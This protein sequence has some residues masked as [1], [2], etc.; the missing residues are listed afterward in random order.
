M[1]RTFK[2][3]LPIILCLVIICSI[4]WY[5]FSYDRGFLQDMLLGSARYFEEQGNH[6]MATWLYKQAYLH[7]GN[8]DDVVIE[9]AERFIKI[10]NYTQAEVVLA[11]AIKEGASVELYIALSKT[12]VEQDKLLDAV[13]MLENITNPDIK[14]Q[15]DAMRPAAPVA[16]PASGYY[17]QYMNITINYDESDSLYVA[18]DKD[19]P[20]VRDEFSGGITLVGGENY[21]NAIVVNDLGLVS[22]PAYFSYIVGGVIEEVSIS[23]P[24]L[25]SHLR[26]ILNLSATQKMFTNDL[27]TI[28]SLTVPQGVTDLSDLSKLTYLESLTME[29]VPIETLQ[30]LSSMTQLNSLTIRGCPLS[31]TD[32]RFIA[33][34]PSL[35][36]LTLNNCALTNISSLENASRLVYLDLADNTIKDLSGLSF[37]D[38]LTELNLSGNALTNLSPLSALG[39]L[40]ILNVSYNS[41]TSIAPLFA[42][43]KLSVLNAA[44]NMIAEIPVFADPTILTELVLTSNEL[45]AIDALANYTSLK[46][47]GLAYNQISDVSPLASLKKLENVNLSHNKIATLPSWSKSCALVNL[48]V[49]YN[50]ITS[51]TALRGLS[52]L[53]EVN[54]DNNKISSINALAECYNLVRVSVF[55]NYVK[56]VS[57]LTAL[58]IIVAYN[59]T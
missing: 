35:E 9:L 6:E 41:L 40:T 59:P 12:Y 51:V 1:K 33:I 34:L 14:A 38:K 20:S 45:S 54:L 15:L 22:Q 50:K 13:S 39:N 21:I 7:S 11:N 32:L 48:D 42:C 2:R 5:L 3:F 18:L 17:T 8:D 46:G 36:R 47:L 53:N 23:D 58:D 29:N 25:D 30:I 44:N 57:K 43:P 10:G 52:F 27:W 19:F 56:D 28:T 49:S 24:I 37:M 31:A 4:V 26:E 55:N 16:T